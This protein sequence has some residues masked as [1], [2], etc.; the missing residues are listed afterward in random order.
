MGIPGDDRRVRT[1]SS[2]PA[3]RPPPTTRRPKHHVYAGHSPIGRLCRGPGYHTGTRSWARR[4]TWASSTLHRAGRFTFAPPRRG[5]ARQLLLLGGFRRDGSSGNDGF[6]SVL[7]KLTLSALGAAAG[8]ITLGAATGGSS[9]GMQFGAGCTGN[10]VWGGLNG[11]K[12][13]GMDCIVGGVLALA[14]WAYVGMRS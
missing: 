12:D 3:P 9:V 2:P 8:G 13:P 6:W 1:P 11:S 5:S 7:G 10:V 4:G 14:P